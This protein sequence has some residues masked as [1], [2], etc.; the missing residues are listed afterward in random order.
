MTVR[1]S[2]NRLGLELVKQFEGCKLKAYVC[3]AG[4]LTIGY[5]STGKHVKPGM[6]ITQDQADELLRSDLRRFEDGVSDLCK[7]ATD[8]QFSALVSFAF[9]V[10]LGSL[11][12]ST[13]RRMHNEGYYD[14]AAGQFA[15]WN[16]G[17]GRVLAGL[18]KRRAS[19]AALYRLKA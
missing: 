8:N 5:G 19:E 11:T 14:Q 2:I 6:V 4:V 1:R 12:T 3:P 17:G 13:L 15:R 18:T 7:V 10:G 16:K 9:N